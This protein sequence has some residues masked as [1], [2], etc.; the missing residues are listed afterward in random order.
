MLFY[1]VYGLIDDQWQ[2]VD[3]KWIPLNEAHTSMA[4]ALQKGAAIVGMYTWD[5]A[6]MNWSTGL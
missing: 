3:G 6:F 1:Y 2:P 5:G 4:L